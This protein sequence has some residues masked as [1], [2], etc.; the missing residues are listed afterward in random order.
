MHSNIAVVAI[1][2]QGIPPSFDGIRVFE[3]RLPQHS[4][5]A[6]TQEGGHPQPRN[7]QFPGRLWGHRLDNVLQ[8]AKSAGVL[9]GVRLQCIFQTIPSRIPPLPWTIYEVAH[10]PARIPLNVFISGPTTAGCPVTEA[11]QAPLAVN[12]ECYERVCGDADINPYVL[13]SAISPNDADGSVIVDW[14]KEKLEHVPDMCIELDSTAHDYNIR[15]IPLPRTKDPA[16]VRASLVV[17][18]TERLRLVAPIPYRSESMISFRSVPNNDPE[19]ALNPINIDT[20]DTL[21]TYTH[22]LKKF[23]GKINH[24]HGYHIR[25]RIGS[26]FFSPG[27]FQAETY[28]CFRRIPWMSWFHGGLLERRFEETPIISLDNEYQEGDLC[29]LET[30][31]NPTGESRDIQYYADKI[32]AVG[33]K[34]LIDSTFGPPPLQYPFKFGTKYFGGHSDLLCGIVIVKTTE[35]ETGATSEREQQRL[36][37]P[38][39]HTADIDLRGIV[40]DVMGPMAAAV[41]FSQLLTPSYRDW[42]YDSDGGSGEAGQVHARTWSDG[43]QVTLLE[44]AGMAKGRELLHEFFVF[45]AP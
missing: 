39:S 40:D 10:R 21:R 3:K 12:A 44:P 30:P 6:S 11:Y 15:Q 1:L 37:D 35:G 24:G 17:P 14:W 36:M 33:G 23:W 2:Y 8:E 19:A 20:L 7:A 43:S 31:L 42:A 29:W 22:V 25:I 26:R 41:Q 45:G 5:V 28:R 32:H 16:L 18:I 13:S 9:P 4:A 34:L 38:F 27:A